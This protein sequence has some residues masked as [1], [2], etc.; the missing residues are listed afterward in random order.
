MELQYLIWI[1]VGLSFSLYIGIVDLV[2]CRLNKS[3]MLQEVGFTPLP[4]EWQPQLTGCRQPL[5]YPWQGLSP[6]VAMMVLCTLWAGQGAMYFLHY[7]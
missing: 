7:F 6:L 1:A 5:L 2:T 3:F 4:M